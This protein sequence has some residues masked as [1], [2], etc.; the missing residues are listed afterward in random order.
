MNSLRTVH[1]AKINFIFFQDIITCVLGIL[2]LVT[3]MLSL[4]LDTGEAATPEEEQLQNQLRQPK[5]NLAQIEQQN[6]ST[7]EKQLLLGSLP[8]PTTLE[9]EL[10]LLKRQA[11]TPA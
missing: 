7:E 10:A 1:E 3:L 9:T 11:P 4:S 6:R 8:D 5:E 2:I